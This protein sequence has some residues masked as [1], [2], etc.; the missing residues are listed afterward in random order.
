MPEKVCVRVGGGVRV[1][2]PV[3]VISVDSVTELLYVSVKVRMS[4]C[5]SNVRVWFG[6]SVIDLGAVMVTDAVRTGESVPSETLVVKVS[7]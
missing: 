5:V 7:V 1:T 4:V 3:E 6:D 2:V